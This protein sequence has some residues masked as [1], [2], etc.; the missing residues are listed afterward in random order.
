MNK[1][2]DGARS[3]GRTAQGVRHGLKDRMLE[4]RLDRMH[5]ESERLESEN[6]MLR[7][8]LEESH[9]EH[10]RILDMIDERLKRSKG[11]GGGRLFLLML[12]GAGAYVWMR[13]RNPEMLERWLRGSAVEPQAGM[14]G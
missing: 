7:E 2:T 4:R 10:Q 5:D 12:L 8:Q 1:V 13:I 14:T 9:E 11:K 3:I 6:S